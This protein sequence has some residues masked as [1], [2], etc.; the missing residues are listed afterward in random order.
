VNTTL[1]LWLKYSTRRFQRILSGYKEQ[2]TDQY[3]SESYKNEFAIE[4]CMNS[5]IS[6]IFV[7][8]F[9]LHLAVN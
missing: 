2:S 6:C 9:T 1:G 3:Y 7:L 8:I 5:K 4:L